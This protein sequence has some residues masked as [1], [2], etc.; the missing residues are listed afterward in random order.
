MHRSACWTHVQG[1]AGSAVKPSGERDEICDC[2][3]DPLKVTI[4]QLLVHRQ[5]H[6]RS[7]QL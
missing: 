7:A 3:Y 5:R 4:A 6:D 2:G 1:S